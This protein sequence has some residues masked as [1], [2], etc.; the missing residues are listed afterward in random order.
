MFSGLTASQKIAYGK[1]S[2]DVAGTLS[3][4]TAIPVGQEVTVTITING[5]A[6]TTAEVGA[7]GA[8]T[9]T[10]DTATL[11]A[12][13][14]PYTIA[15]GYAG[16]TNFKTASDSTTTLTV[17]KATPTFSGL[18]ASQKIDYGKPSIDV[19]GTLSGPTASPVGQ[20]VTVTYHDQRGGGDDGGGGGGRRVHG[21][22]RHGDAAG[23]G[24]AV[25]DRLRLCGGHQLRDGQRQ[26]HDADGEQGDAD[27]ERHGRWGHVQHGSVPGDRRVGDGCRHGREARQL[28]RSDP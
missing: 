18:P 5:A 26:H 24:H 25:H 8:F 10:I 12:L 15:Y 17:N 9:A 3:G 16:D 19:A 21:H 11:P 2:I 1:P 22:D 14:T 27:G 13:D 28:R 7:G 23:L 20:E 6:A 4:P